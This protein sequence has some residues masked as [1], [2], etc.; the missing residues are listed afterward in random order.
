MQLTYDYLLDNY[1]LL[2]VLKSTQE[3][4]I[5][6]VL[7]SDRNTYIRRKINNNLAPYF[8]LRDISSPYIARIYYVA[9]DGNQTLV[10]EEYVKGLT[11]NEILEQGKVFGEEQVIQIALDIS[12]GLEKMHAKGIIHR[13]V[14]P[15]NIIL[16]ENG[17]AKIIDF[18]ASRLMSQDK[19]H[20]TRILGTEGYAPP[21]QYG[22]MTTDQRSDWYAVGKTLESLLGSSYDGKLKTVINK[23]VRFDPQDRVSSAQ[24]F[25]KLLN[26]NNNKKIYY[27]LTFLAVLTLG[28]GAW[29][30]TKT[31][32]DRTRPLEPALSDKVEQKTQAAEKSQQKTHLESKSTSSENA[33]SDTT[34]IV[35]KSNETKN[36]VNKKQAAS[37]ADD[38]WEKRK[39]TMDETMPLRFFDTRTIVLKAVSPEGSYPRELSCGNMEMLQ[40]F[41]LFQREKNISQAVIRLVFQNFT[42]IPPKEETVP[43]LGNYREHI[44]FWPKGDINAGLTIDVSHYWKSNGFWKPYNYY[45]PLLGGRAFKY[46]QLGPNP[47]IIATLDFQ[48]GQKI[49]KI[50]PIKIL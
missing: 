40:P 39:K 36:A 35:P 43:Y 10:I 28:F 41:V 19:Y 33:N 6:L 48:D 7:G 26:G 15:G 13:D 44:T 1:K 46:Y 8:Q 12:H 11:L 45:Y 29:W 25:R 27:L 21:E 32:V 18:N 42:I 2:E 22:F 16:Q 24:E 37:S 20:D 9:S 17:H 14:K 5:E 23:C 31:T 47:R 34:K 30:H 38:S 4:T 50:I 49:S 3:Y